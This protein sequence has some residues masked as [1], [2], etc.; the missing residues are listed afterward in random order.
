LIHPGGSDIGRRS[1]LKTILGILLTLVV[2][3]LAMYLTTGV[4]AQY[5]C[6]D[7]GLPGYG[8]AC[9]PQ[10]TGN[11]N[12]SFWA[13]IGVAVLGLA[14]ML[15][16]VNRNTMGGNENL[17]AVRQSGDEGAITTEQGARRGKTVPAENGVVPVV[18]KKK[19]VPFG[20]WLLIAVPGLLLVGLFIKSFSGGG[21]SATTRQQKVEEIAP[22]WPEE[23]ADFKGLKFGMG[24]SEARK[25]AGL[26]DCN[27]FEHTWECRIHTDLITFDVIFADGRLDSITGDFTASDFD[28]LEEVFASK[29]GKPS[30]ANDTI[31]QN[32]FGGAF[33]QRELRWDGKVMNIQLNRFARSYEKDIPGARQKYDLTRGQLYVLPVG[34]GQDSAK[35]SGEKRKSILE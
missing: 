35:P 14:V 24:L 3:D 8:Q 29:Y 20:G 21:S 17:G 1:G 33:Q 16:L 26:K 6:V 15:A 25:T 11:I 34:Y 7:T 22:A 27:S 10:L 13:C 4:I 30:R 31:L 12:V 19:R 23:P 5:G 9:G 32:A 18:P 2:L 28:Q